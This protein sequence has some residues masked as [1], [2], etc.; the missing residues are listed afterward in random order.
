MN[1]SPTVPNELITRAWD[2]P[3]L[4]NLLYHD[5]ESSTYD[6][7]WAIS[8]DER[9]VEYARRRFV[10]VAGTQGWPYERSLE[11]GCGA[12]AFTLNL[13]RAGVM[14]S[15][16]VTDI[17]P[18]MVKVAQ[19]NARGLGIDV[20]GRVADAE[21]IPF[22]DSEFDLVIGHEVLH[23]IPDVEQALRESLRVLRPGGRF[24]FCGEP[25]KY[26][27]AVGSRLSSAARWAMARAS[28]LP[29][30]GKPFN[31][32]PPSNRSSSRLAELE[33]VV[34]IHT[35]DPASLR[36]TA[37]RAGAVDVATATEELTAAWFNG[38]VRAVEEVMNPGSVGGSW[39]QLT[40]RGW[41][42]LAALD[43]RVLAKVVPAGL[44]YNVCITGTKA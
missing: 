2:D 17:S 33:A 16:V 36:R 22:R 42:S 13:H 7:N 24:V 37:M 3:R 26:G 5:W 20:E 43:E 9:A 25:T 34:Q 18:G 1:V 35:F 28:T 19:R 38:P 14:K 44:F 12:G 41:V 15:A 27:D 31:S 4:A 8:Y 39:S 6:A 40:H 11:L 29:G 10:H 23:H 21:R 30:V 32:P